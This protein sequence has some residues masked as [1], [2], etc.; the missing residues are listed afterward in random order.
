MPL[1]EHIFRLDCV[2]PND[3]NMAWVKVPVVILRP[4]WGQHL[5]NVVV[6][7]IN[8]NL[9]KAVIIARIDISIFLSLNRLVLYDICRAAR[10][11]ELNMVI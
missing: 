6:W 7:R 5:V 10:F 1:V 9:E 11:Y 8:V 2:L 3:G 4:D